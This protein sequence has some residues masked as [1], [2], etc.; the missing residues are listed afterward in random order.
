MAAELNAPSEDFVRFFAGKVYSGKM[1]TAAREKF[2]QTTQR[3]L[4]QFIT[5]QLNE[6]LK[7][8]LGGGTPVVAEAPAPAPSAPP[9]DAPAAEAEAN[10]KPAVVTTDDER[11]AFFIV[12]AI[13]REVVDVKRIALRDQQTYCSVLLDDNN[14]RPIA[15]FLFD[16]AKKQVS[17]FDN[18]QRKEERLPIETL[19]DL[20]GLAARIKAA[21]ALYQK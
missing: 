16:R 13:L 7:S 19:D 8:A 11:E 3:A 4:R 12:R 14:R 1:T 20:Y 10:G 5:D 21:V 17:L 2:A 18:E 15:R 6:R 9:A